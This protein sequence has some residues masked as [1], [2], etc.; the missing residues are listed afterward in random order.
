MATAVDVSGA[1]Y[2]AE[3]HGHRILPME[4]T[5]LVPAL[6]GNPLHRVRP[7][8]WEHEGNRA[9]R[10]GPW[11]LVMKFKGPW[12]LYNLDRDRTEQNNVIAKFPSVAQ[13]LERQWEDWAAT[14]FVD[15]WIGERCNDWGEEPHQP[16][17][18]KPQAKTKT[19]PP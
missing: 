9:V 8:F 10:S 18:P 13:L 2:P 1:L 5:S 14:S 6:N 12:E 7:I 19:A 16:A 17:K 3:F 4:G 11:K 15:D